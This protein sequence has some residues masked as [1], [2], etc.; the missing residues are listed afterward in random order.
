VSHVC[1]ITAVELHFVL[2]FDA[3]DL[4]FADGYHEPEIC[5]KVKA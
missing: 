3:S 2:N 5:Q 1:E 4:P